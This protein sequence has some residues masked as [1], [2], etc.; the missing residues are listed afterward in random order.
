[1]INIILIIIGA[2]A[3]YYLFR[4]TFLKKPADCSGCSG[5]CETCEIY[6]KN[7]YKKLQ[8]GFSD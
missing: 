5:N 2:A 6:T 3:G 4:K 8:S 7:N 1:M